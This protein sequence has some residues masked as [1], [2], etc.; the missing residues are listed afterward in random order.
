MGRE[1]P[2]CINRQESP[3]YWDSH[4]QW[5]CPDFPAW[6]LMAPLNA[7]PLRAYSGFLFAAKMGKLAIH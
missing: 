5:A 4:R 3:P 6:L 2:Q 1:S 7:I